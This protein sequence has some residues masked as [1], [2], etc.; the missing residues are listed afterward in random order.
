MACLELF[1]LAVTGGAIAQ[2]ARRRGGLGW[3][4]VVVAV[5]GYFVV[6]AVVGR[7]AGSGPGLLAAAG[8]VTLVFLSVF[9]VVGGVRMASEPWQCPDCQFFNEPSTLVCGCGREYE[10]TSGG[11]WDL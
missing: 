6:G 5:A 2:L 11:K 8:W 9:V 7:A 3:P 1:F 4:F 10:K